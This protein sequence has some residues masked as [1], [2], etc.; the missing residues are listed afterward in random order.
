M[1]DETA[2]TSPFH[3]GEIAVQER[4]GVREP[5]ERVGRAVIRRVMPP[6]HQELFARL[7]AVFVG[8]VDTADRPWASVLVGRPGF[9]HA[10]DE[11]TLRIDA[12]P[13]R[14]DPLGV[15]LGMGIP[16][17]LLGIELATRRRNRM[18][19]TV[20]AIDDDGFAVTVDQSFGNCPQYIQARHGAWRRDPSTFGAPHAIEP[21]DARLDGA[22]RRIVE[23]ADTFFIASAARDARGH[24]GPAGVD[25]SHRGGK[26][27]FVRITTREP[28]GPSV[29]VIPDFRG[30][31]LFNTLG[32]V[33][34]NPRAGLVF[35]DFESGDVLQLTGRAEIVWDGA[36]LESFAGAHRLLVVT[37]ENGIRHVDVLPFTWSEP[38]YA[39]QLE[40]TGAWPDASAGTSHV[41]PGR[42]AARRIVTRR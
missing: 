9:A 37:L 27:G 21:I 32:N 12:S 29:L 31:Y 33:V 23:R 5:I 38:T 28:G 39:R 36:E 30:N 6:E 22:A 1:D 25:V 20:I 4:C 19:G 13:T 26:A 17:G 11:R 7:P 14:G 8:S 3:D 15:A 24:A 41:H 40:E 34:A 10:D 42:V 16:V 18:N 2:T 35:L